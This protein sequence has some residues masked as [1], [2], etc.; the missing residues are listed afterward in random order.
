MLIGVLAALCQLVAW[1]IKIPTILFLLL[2]GIIIGPVS[3]Y[4]HPDILFGP[5]LFPLIYLSVAI[6]LF[7]GSLTLKFDQIR[8]QG[9]IVSH[10]LTIG[11]LI[12]WAGISLVT[13]WLFAFNW[14]LSVMF[15][16]IMV[17]TGPTVI[18]PM[19]QAIRAEAKIAHI[20]RWEGIAIDPLGSLLAVIVFGFIVYEPN[21]LALQY[22]LLQFPAML[23]GGAALGVINGFLLSEVLRRHW[24]PEFLQNIVV[25][26]WVILVCVIAG[27]IS[28]GM[29]L[30][31]VTIMGIVIANRKYVPLESILDFKETLSTLLLSGLF[32]ILAA[33]TDLARIHELLLPSLLLYLC[34]QFIIQPLKILVTTWHSDLTWRHKLLL[35]WISP[36]G[37]VAAAMAA[38]FALKLQAVGYHSAVFLTPLAFLVIVYS[39]VLPSLTARP[40][41]KIL[42]VADP[43]PTGVLIIGANKVAR[44]IAKI[45]QQ[46]N[47][48][49]IVTD[50]SWENISAARLEGLTTFFGNPVSEHAD[51]YLNL[52]GIGNL[53]AITPNA[54]LNTL[55]GLRYRNDFGPKGI[56]YLQTGT[57]KRAA[58]KYLV[59]TKHKGQQ[60]FGKD[61]T[62]QQLAS[63]IACGAEIRSTTLTEQFAMAA[64]QAKN[65]DKY[66]PLFAI[67]P[68][69]KLAIF[70]QH[71]QIKTEPG[72]TIMAIDRQVVR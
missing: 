7:E 58:K 46:H 45:L 36:R 10:L 66:I 44:E 27:L 65:K 33:R 47:I 23:L 69:G 61:I 18:K 50:A 35:S 53:L 56:Y 16:A 28:D 59:S 51:N 42:G 6:I 39:V 13:Y 48:H 5:V 55:A 3:G 17:V 72:W 67:N 71:S 4:F 20:L 26:N 52:L 2:V 19:L 41:A 31:A 68:K 34:L 63:L 60:L 8:G 11:I 12:S 24:L 54:D 57:E 37:I 32:I 14:Q 21:G 9:Q 70:A 25:L 1:R 43:D 40:L 22:R 64:Y 29:G 15:S 38:L 30:L 49:T 62:Y